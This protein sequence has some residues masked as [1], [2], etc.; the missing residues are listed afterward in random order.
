M[1]ARLHRGDARSDLTN[2]AGTLV[3][4]NRRE[5]SLAVEAVERIGIGMAN[6]RRLDLDQDLAGLGALQIQ[7]DDLKWLLGLERNSGTCLHLRLLLSLFN[8]AKRVI[9]DF[10]QSV[11]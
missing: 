9:R 6:S 2:D 1:V 11:I 8:T 10:P 4:E 5:N 3:A 7:L